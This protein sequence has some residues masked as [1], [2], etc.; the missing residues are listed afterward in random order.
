MIKFDR[1]LSESVQPVFH[2]T[3]PC[4]RTTLTNKNKPEKRHAASVT[5]QALN[6]KTSAL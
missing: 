3:K 5:W 6:S 1:C 2:S 4:P